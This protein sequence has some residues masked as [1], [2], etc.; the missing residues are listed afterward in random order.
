MKQP[1]QLTTERISTIESTLLDPNAWQPTELSPIDSTRHKDLLKQLKMQFILDCALLDQQQ[2]QNQIPSEINALL[3]TSH[4][5]GVHGTLPAHHSGVH[6]PTNQ[7]HSSPSQ[8]IHAQTVRPP[9]TISHHSTTV[10]Y[11]PIKQTRKKPKIK[12]VYEDP[13]AIKEIGEV[14]ESIYG[15]LEEVFTTKVIE[16]TKPPDKQKVLTEVYHVNHYT[17]AGPYRTTRK[18]KHRRGGKPVLNRYATRKP[19]KRRVIYRTKRTTLM[20]GSRSTKPIS[21]YATNNKNNYLS[22]KIHVTSEYN[23]PNPTSSLDDVKMDG[24]EYS[25]ESDDIYDAMGLDALNIDTGSYDESDSNTEED[26]DDDYPLPSHKVKDNIKAKRKNSKKI[27]SHDSSYEDYSDEESGSDE[28]SGVSGFFSNFYSSFRNM[29]PT[30][31]PFSFFSKPAESS[32]EERRSTTPRIEVRK[33]KQP[34]L[35]YAEPPSDNFLD[36]SSAD[37]N[38]YNPFFFDSDEGF[39]ATTPMTPAADDSFW[40]WFGSDE[41]TGP[42]DNTGTNILT[43]FDS[44]NRF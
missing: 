10:E 27:D 30:L 38:W 2:N 25:E 19:G 44:H 39:P 7:H 8:N 37:N 18:M 9:V 21:K 6:L 43:L 29:M 17:P 24:S 5:S 28:S 32:S 41:E 4:H 11:V 13:P 14:L 42:E 16:K 34:S 35:I 40:N 3:K 36:E 33:P 31:K 22:T 20:P 15:Y 1:N 12:N 23:E 26:E